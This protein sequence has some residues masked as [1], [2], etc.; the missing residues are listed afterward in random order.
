MWWV[1]IPLFGNCLVFLLPSS[2]SA[3]MYTSF[4]LSR[5]A[6]FTLHITCVCIIFPPPF[7]LL[8]ACFSLT[9]CTNLFNWLLSPCS[10]CFPYHHAKC[11]TMKSAT[12]SI[13]QRSINSSTTQPINQYYLALP[14]LPIDQSTTTTH[15]TYKTINQINSIN[16]TI[17]HA[18][19]PIY[20][21]LIISSTYSCL[22][23]A[24]S[25]GTRY[26]KA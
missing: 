6:L 26:N 2:P 14:T 8:H 23:K 24:G 13:A 10:L 21:G 17:N 4:L 22:R 25:L 1:L 19:Y 9:L 20:Q 18:I 5:L 16:Q 11:R 7:P 15:P 3:L 12:L